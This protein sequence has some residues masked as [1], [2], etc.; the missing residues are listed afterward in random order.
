MGEDGP[1][2]HEELRGP[3]EESELR[4]RDLRRELKETERSWALSGDTEALWE[5]EHELLIGLHR[6][7]DIHSVIKRARRAKRAM[8]PR[9]DAPDM[10]QAALSLWVL[11][12]YEEAVE[13]LRVAVSRLPDNRYPWSLILRHLTWDRHPREAIEFI[14]A[15]L[16]RVPWRRHA[17]VQ[18][19][20]LYVDAAA[21][22]LKGMEFA[23]CRHQLGEARRHLTAAEGEGEGRTVTR[24][25]TLVETLEG[26][27]ASTESALAAPEGEEL[28]RLDADE[29]LVRGIHKV[30]EASGVR[31]E[32]EPDT[33]L[34]LDEVERTARME[35]PEED[36][37]RKV[38]VLEVTPE[39]PP[40]L[41][42]RKREDRQ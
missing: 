8:G 5:R 40:G 16:D 34:D 13:V 7:G 30:A 36:R 19:G 10:A 22:A 29:R 28:R 17:L 38:T 27:C 39:R 24:L 15:D 33:E 3:T 32:G 18:L 6:A 42:W 20:T 12:R 25:M 9:G 21:R 23:E 37:E 2:P 41:R 31:L 4:K 1:E 11:E 14:E 26:R 35:L